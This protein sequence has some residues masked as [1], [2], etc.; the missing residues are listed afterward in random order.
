MEDKR[1]WS[2][3]SRKLAKEATPE[4]LAEIEQWLQ[5]DPDH[6]LLYQTIYNYWQTQQLIPSSN[7]RQAWNALLNKIAQSEQ[8]EK[9]VIFDLN[10][11]RWR[12]LKVAAVVS[13]LLVA[14]LLVTRYYTQPFPYENAT[15]TTTLK[16]QRTHI[17][18][19]DGST[20]W[21]NADSKLTYYQEFGEKEREV[22][23]LGE[24]FFDVKKNPA[25]PFV[26]Q[27]DNS[28]IQVLGTS[29]NVKAYGNEELVET[30]VVTG[31]V[32]FI[33]DQQSTTQAHGTTYY[34][35]PNQKLA[36]SKRSRKVSK[37]E[38]D[39][40]D[41]KAWIEGKLIFN[42]D[43]W[44]QIAKT[45]ERNYDTALIFKNEQI[46]NCHLTATFQENTLKEVLDLIKMTE[47]FSYR[48]EQKSIVITG[49]ACPEP[50]SAMTE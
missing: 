41:D 39:S 6:Q 30:S 37:T 22:H 38:V 14:G 23:L 42:N 16:G 4:E 20:V 2:L 1:I 21:L 11:T 12:W 7:S 34:I 47:E 43:S 32:S 27:L 15:V 48:T 33:A 26:I 9:T 35:T 45:L 25:V 18:L 50:K 3:I 13:L 36:F 31:K 40:Q 44:D 19:P 24:A 49:K 46:R 5:A 10:L 8:Q 29:F 28:R 17:T